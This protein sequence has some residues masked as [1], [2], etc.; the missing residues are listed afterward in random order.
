MEL[1]FFYIDPT[2]TATPE[3]S[4]PEDTSRHIVQVLRMEAGEALLLTDGQGKRMQAI[5]TEAHKRHCGV[6]VTDTTLIPAPTH[7]MTL[8]ISPTKHNS[9]LEW[10]LEKAAELGVSQIIPLICV[11]TEKQQI[12]I[13]RLQ[14]ILISAM[15]QSQQCWLTQLSE[16]MKFRAWVQ[17]PDPGE[18]YMAHCIADEKRLVLADLPIAN[19]LTV[20]IGPEGDFTPEE[21]QLACDAGI[22]P[23]VLGHT[24]LRTETAGM[25]AAHWWRLQLDRL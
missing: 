13:D 12:R 24:R 1:P 25:Y 14:Q 17:L 16:P 23:V 11:R 5:I 2:L 3:I 4:L 8:A 15:L 21:I 20:A 22:Q 7:T 10:L 19:K 18:R 9:R 6:R